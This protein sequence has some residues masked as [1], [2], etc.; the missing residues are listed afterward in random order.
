MSRRNRFLEII[1]KRKKFTVQNIKK[2]I[3]MKCLTNF[4]IEHFFLIYNF[5]NLEA[6][7]CQNE[8]LLSITVFSIYDKS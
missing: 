8:Y 7:L 5:L 6:D 1:I 2:N 4:T 3:D